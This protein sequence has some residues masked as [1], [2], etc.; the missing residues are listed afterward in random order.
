MP[1]IIIS[2]NRYIQG[3]GELNNISKHIGNLGISFIFII[4]KSGL[5]RFESVI[6]ASFKG[7]KNILNFEVFNGECTDMEITRLAKICA[8]KTI[9]API[10]KVIVG[11]S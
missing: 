7:T 11:I 9:I 6:R 8:K 1:K 2:P 4:S 5:K 10:T 3:K